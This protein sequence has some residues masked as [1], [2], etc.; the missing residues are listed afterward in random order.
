MSAPAPEEDRLF[1]EAAD[2]IIRLQN[3]PDNPV[4]IEMVQQWRARSPAHEQA[5]AEVAEIHGMAGKILKDQRV[6]E[7][8]EKLGLTRRNLMIGA[9]IGLGA[10]AA[11]K[12]VVPDLLIAA[13]ADHLTRTAEIRPV[14]LADGTMATLG[15]DSAFALA[16]TDA[17]RRVELLA[18]MCYFE[19]PEDARPFRVAAGGAIATATAGA[20]DVSSDAGFLTLSV[21][22]GRVDLSAP[23]AP[24]PAARE[25]IDAGNWLTVEAGAV[26]VER[27]VR[28]PS[29]IASWREG[30][31]VAER[32]TVSAVVARIARWQPGRTVMLDG[33]LGAR[34]VNGVYDIR[35]PVAALEAVVHPFGGKVRQLPGYLTV[36]SPV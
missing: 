15:P 20:F 8:R 33:A 6:A 34:R 16:Y 28:E 36:V 23:A 32:E 35:Q 22:R 9:G 18:G 29:Q 4:S 13:R 27:G 25:T 11:G 19:V 30:L 7:R 12:L 14:S 10:Y 31:I 3:D 17:E 24:L 26:R 21:N 2:L 1:E 5:W